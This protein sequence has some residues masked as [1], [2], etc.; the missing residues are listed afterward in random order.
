[1]MRF[2]NSIWLRLCRLSSRNSANVSFAAARSSPTSVRTKW[3]RLPARSLA[4]SNE[5]SS[6]TPAA[7]RIRWSSARS[8]AD[9]GRPDRTLATAA[10]AGGRA[11][12]A[13]HP[14]TGTGSHTRGNRQ[15]TAAGAAAQQLKSSPRG[16]AAIAPGR[17]PGGCH[18]HTSPGRG[19]PASVRVGGAW[20]SL[21]PACGRPVLEPEGR[22]RGGAVV[23]TEL[24]GWR[25]VSGGR[26]LAQRSGQA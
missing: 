16:T 25:V 10:S 11:H 8:S 21:Q 22:P 26:S 7:T 24:L 19:L 20:R 1:M 6:P 12:A 14:S 9:S 17:V 5:V 3:P 18:R 4:S 23:T 13:H 2:T 15:F